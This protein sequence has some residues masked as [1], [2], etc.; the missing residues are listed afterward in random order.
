[1]N[2]CRRDLPMCRGCDVLRGDAVVHDGAI[3]VDVDVIDDGCVIKNLRDVR[4]RNG[5]NA[6][7]GVAKIDRR[8]K[9]K[10]AWRKAEI[11]SNAHPVAVIAKTDARLPRRERRQRRPS[12]IIIRITPRHP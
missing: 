1:M 7:V 2:W 3:D 10:A 5:A 11:E 9:N 8:Y 12:A 4:R 6:Q